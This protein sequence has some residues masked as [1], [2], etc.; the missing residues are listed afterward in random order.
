MAEEINDTEVDAL[1]VEADF[2]LAETFE[3]APRLRLVGICRNAL[4][5]I[6]L[7]AATDGGVTV[8]NAPGRNSGRWRNWLSG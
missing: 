2:V 3:G 6:D 7:D 1:I 8:V 4:T 5:Q